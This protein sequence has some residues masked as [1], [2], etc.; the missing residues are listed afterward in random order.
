M[1]LME[2][3]SKSIIAPN[4]VDFY[5]VGRAILVKHE[6]SFDLYDQVFAAVFREGRCHRR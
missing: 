1:T 3:L 6:A 2:A 4:L 5:R